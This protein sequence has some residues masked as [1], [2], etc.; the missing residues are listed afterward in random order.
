MIQLILPLLQAPL[1]ATG[2]GTWEERTTHVDFQSHQQSGTYGQAS[3]S[4]KTFEPIFFVLN[5][6]CDQNGNQF[7]KAIAAKKCSPGK[8]I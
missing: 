3:H 8:R 7:D 4:P 5:F 6:D 2:R 1:E